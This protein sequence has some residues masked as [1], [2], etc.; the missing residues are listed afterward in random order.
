VFFARH[1][2]KGQVTFDVHHFAR[3]QKELFAMG[4]NAELQIK[5]QEEKDM[6]L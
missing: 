2:I 6:H 3:N 5:E 4:N 1:D